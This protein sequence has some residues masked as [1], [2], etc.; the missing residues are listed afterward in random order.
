[1]T[2]EELQIATDSDYQTSQSGLNQEV[3][4]VERKKRGPVVVVEDP[5]EERL[6]LTKSELSFIK[7]QQKSLKTTQASAQPKYQVKNFGKDNAK[8][9]EYRFKLGDRALDEKIVKEHEE[10]LRRNETQKK[11]KFKHLIEALKSKNAT[12]EV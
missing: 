3:E 7:S 4:L 1:M 6:K 8:A 9:F 10:M 5:G 11:Y 2:Q 12:T